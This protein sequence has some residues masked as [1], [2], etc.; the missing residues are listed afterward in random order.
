[1]LI[2][3]IRLIDETVKVQVLKVPVAKPNII[4]QVISYMKCE[5]QLQLHHML[6]HPMTTSKAIPTMNEGSIFSCTLQQAN[7]TPFWYQ[8]KSRL[9]LP[10]PKIPSF[11]C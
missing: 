7:T 9:K 1:M 3:F 11:R 2:D 10:F 5:T 4:K 8:G 6:F